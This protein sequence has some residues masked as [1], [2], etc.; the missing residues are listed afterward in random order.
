[1]KAAHQLEKGGVGIQRGHDG[2]GTEGAALGEPDADRS[3][4][5]HQDLGDLGGI[6]DG[7]AVTDDLPRQGARELV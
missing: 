3:A 1:M 4:V 7:S 2:L 5:L 6:D